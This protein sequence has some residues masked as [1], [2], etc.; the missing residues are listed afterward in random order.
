MQ[1]D[2]SQ[3]IRARTTLSTN[4]GDWDLIQRACSLS[5]TVPGRFIRDAVVRSARG[6]VAKKERVG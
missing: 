5:E 3:K 2:E 6:V 1:K 4:D